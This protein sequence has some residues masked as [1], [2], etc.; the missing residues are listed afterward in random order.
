MY[1]RAWQPG[2]DPDSGF[3]KAHG[4]FPPPR[5]SL[6]LPINP[7]TGSLQSRR[8]AW[9]PAGTWRFMASNG[10]RTDRRPSRSR[11]S[12]TSRR[13]FLAS[14][15]ASAVA[16]VPRDALRWTRIRGNTLPAP[17]LAPEARPRVSLPDTRQRFGAP[18]PGVRWAPARPCLP[19]P[20]PRASR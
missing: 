19:A 3:P 2:S 10:P 11:E 8:R 13:I 9:L 12:E 5:C 15:P 17:R 1:S 20:G 14:L 4:R 18:A 16:E 7:D 6:N